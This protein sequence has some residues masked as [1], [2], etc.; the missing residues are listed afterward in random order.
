VLAA[1]AGSVAIAF[2]MLISP[3]AAT[4]AA[5]GRAWLLLVGLIS[6]VVCALVALG[7]SLAA[8]IRGEDVGPVGRGP[9]HHPRRDVVQE[10]RPSLAVRPSRAMRR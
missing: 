7:V 4:A 9:R 1:V 6:M 10:P 3:P 2:G 8:R 5:D